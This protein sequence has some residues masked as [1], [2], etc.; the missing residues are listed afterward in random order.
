MN[1]ALV[2]RMSDMSM[3][4]SHSL[5][6]EQAHF[7]CGQAVAKQDTKLRVHQQDT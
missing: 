5:I 7:R 1:N 3:P 6:K 4:G 2:K